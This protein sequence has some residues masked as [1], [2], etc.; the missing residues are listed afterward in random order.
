LAAGTQGAVE[1][2]VRPAVETDLDAIYALECASFATDRLSRRGLRRFLKAS[3]RPLLVARSA[4]RVVGY[5]VVRLYARSA[6]I[7]SLAVAEAHGRRGV[8]RELLHAAERYAR[9]HGRT[10]LT[11]EVRYDNARA[12]AL[13]EKLGYCDF[14]RYPGYYADG[15]EALRFA[16]TLSLQNR[17]QK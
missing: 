10:R 8:G 16:K 14:G 7:Y 1:F 9:A 15:A 17:A 4:G 6:R 12:I 2:V 11:L 5:I 13:Y 3:H